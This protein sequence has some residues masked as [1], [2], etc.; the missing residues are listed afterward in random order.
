MINIKGDIKRSNEQ[1][2]TKLLPFMTSIIILL[3][4][5][6]FITTLLQM[7]YLQISI[8][9]SPQFDVN[10]SLSGLQIDSAVNYQQK[11]EVTRLRSLI[12]LEDVAMAKQYHQA[13]VLLMSRLWIS[14]IGFVTGMI[15][16]FT[17]AA[18]ILGKLIE[19]PSTLDA[20]SGENKLSFK[21]ASPGLMLCLLG[22]VLMLAT[23]VVHHQNDVKHVA[24]YFRDNRMAAEL[25][26]IESMPPLTKPSDT[27]SN[28]DDIKP[29]LRISKSDTSTN[30]NQLKK[31]TPD[32]FI[33]K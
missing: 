11:I 7:I 5:F 27:A 28:D 29:I 15:L 12:L 2:Q 21:T 22:T 25:S 18:F 16:A 33:K 4:V 3:A 14:Y 32:T 19:P 20:A 13:N 9:N 24:V 6:F 30:Q 1:W 8:A 23:I 26:N 31:F 17:G 10:K